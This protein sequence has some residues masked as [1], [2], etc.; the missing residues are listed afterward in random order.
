MNE[1]ELFDE[2]VEAGHVTPYS[3]VDDILERWLAG[4]DVSEWEDDGT[5]AEIK[6]DADGA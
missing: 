4:E 5:I 3:E 1:D 6:E 2:L